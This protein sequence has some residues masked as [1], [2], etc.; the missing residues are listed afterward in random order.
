MSEECRIPHGEEVIQMCFSNGL[1]YAFQ[2]TY[3]RPRAVFGD[4]RLQRTTYW[5][6]VYSGV[7][8]NNLV[9]LDAR[10]FR[11]THLGKPSVDHYIGQVYI[12]AIG[13]GVNVVRYDGTRL[14][15]H[16]TLKCVPGASAV[17]V[18]SREA[19]YVCDSVNGTVCL[20]DIKKDR[21]TARLDAP[22]EI[23]GDGRCP[24]HIAVV[25]DTILVSYPGPNLVIYRHGISARG[26]MVPRPQGLTSVSALS[27]DNR[28]CFLV[29]DLPSSTVF[30]LDLSGKL[31]RAIRL[32]VNDAVDC[33]VVDGQLLVLRKYERLVKLL[34]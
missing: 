32:P 22:L 24:H 26:K 16:P 11:S 5:I 9:Q 6:T 29:T 7:K 28:K 3:N 30:V 18:V 31:I 27:T 34:P 2:K 4:V 33:T 14:L 13:N 12:P 17:A 25:G 8:E 23:H 20:V 19:L 10:G 1:F 15:K 21:V